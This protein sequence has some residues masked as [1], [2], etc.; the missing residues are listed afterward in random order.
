MLYL[1]VPNVVEMVNLFYVCVC[2]PTCMMAL[3]PFADST[4]VLPC[5]CAHA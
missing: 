4:G 5:L 1:C 2:V 3:D